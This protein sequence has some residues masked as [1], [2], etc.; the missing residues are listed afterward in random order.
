MLLDSFQICNK[1]AIDLNLSCL[2]GAMVKLN[3]PM[4]CQ[5]WTSYL[6]VTN[7]PCSNLFNHFVS[8]RARSI[9]KIITF[10]LPKW[11]RFESLTFETKVLNYNVTNYVVGCLLF[12]TYKMVNKWWIYLEPFSSSLFQGIWMDI[13]THTHV[14]RY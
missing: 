14:A 9:C 13:H 6:M 7:V 5:Q 8:Q 2:E 12:V 4:E 1:N 3:M 11:S 10:K